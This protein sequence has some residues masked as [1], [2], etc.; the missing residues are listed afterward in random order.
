MI[1][2]ISIISNFFPWSGWFGTTGFGSRIRWV[3]LFP[4]FIIPIYFLNGEP[5]RNQGD[6]ELNGNF[7]EGRYRISG[8]SPERIPARSLQNFLDLFAR[9]RRELPENS[10][11]GGLP[12]VDVILATDGGAFRDLSGQGAMVAGLY[13][14]SR[15]SFL[16]QNP[17]V[18]KNKKLLTSTIRHEC[19]HEALTNLSTFEGKSPPN[20]ALQELY[21]DAVYPISQSPQTI[22]P[23]KSELPPR[24][25]LFLERM[26]IELNSRNPE[27]IRRARTLLRVFGTELIRTRGRETAFRFVLGRLQKE[28]EK[29]VEGDYQAFRQIQESNWK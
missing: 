23:G 12:P 17:A 9:L 2:K 25:N 24:L 5:N 29:T 22:T 14:Q 4:L 13:I 28:K 11:A 20:G 16:F 10:L 1:K 8:T 15:Q 6:H 21:C 26:E 27:K 19:C 7:S 18:L 3:L